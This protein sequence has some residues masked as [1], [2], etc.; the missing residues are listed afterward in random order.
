MPSPEDFANFE[1]FFADFASPPGFLHVLK[2]RLRLFATSHRLILT[3]SYFP[4]KWGILKKYYFLSYN[5]ST[6]KKH[7]TKYGSEYF[8][9]RKRVK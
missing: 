6:L 3:H 9:S 7:E 1:T 2:L 5:I 4:M 8:V